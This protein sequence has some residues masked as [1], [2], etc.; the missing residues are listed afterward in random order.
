M[1]DIVDTIV[2]HGDGAAV[3]AEQILK[4][5]L[6]GIQKHLDEQEV[7]QRREGFV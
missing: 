7:P 1:R 5:L 3:S 6:G 4:V 2:Y